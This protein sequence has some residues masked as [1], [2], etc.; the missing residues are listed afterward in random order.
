MAAN[1]LM[2]NDDAVSGDV[3]REQQEQLQQARDYLVAAMHHAG[4]QPAAENCPN[5]A[6]IY[7]FLAGLL[8]PTNSHRVTLLN[9]LSLLDR[10]II[11]LL[12][13]NLMLNLSTQEFRDQHAPLMDQYHQ[14]RA[15]AG[16]HSE[17]QLHSELDNM[18]SAYLNIPPA[19][20]ES[21][22]G[23]NHE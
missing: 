18:T 19:A 7:A 10:E 1:G 5:Y 2:V 16:P 20:G 17:E 11:Q 23:W 4:S 22:F 9:E 12:T 8:D 6:K 13:Q 15:K 21:T 14:L 3:A